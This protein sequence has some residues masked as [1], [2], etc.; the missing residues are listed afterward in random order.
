MYSW[1]GGQS[2]CDR[3]ED[4]LCQY[5]YLTLTYPFSLPRLR[6]GGVCCTGRGRGVWWWTSWIMTHINLYHHI[7]HTLCRKICHRKN[8]T[9][10]KYLVECSTCCRDPITLVCQH[11]DISSQINLKWLLLRCT[12]LCWKVDTPK[13]SWV[14]KIARNK[15]SNTNR[16]HSH[17]Q[18]AAHS[19]RPTVSGSL[20][21]WEVDLGSDQT[22]HPS[23]SPTHRII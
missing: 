22:H 9:L 4:F 8:I 19:L 1:T 23:G 7:T 5:I 14:V 17:K 12:K 2:V 10:R 13:S 20:S 6:P 21:N 18:L 11:F 16:S 15:A 3:Q